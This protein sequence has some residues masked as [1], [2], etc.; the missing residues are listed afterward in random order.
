V[1]P[2]AVGIR[3]LTPHFLLAAHKIEQVV[4]NYNTNVFFFSTPLQMYFF[5]DSEK[6]F[7]SSQHHQI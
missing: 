4:D 2:A 6:Y 3:P 7:L 1:V 5:K